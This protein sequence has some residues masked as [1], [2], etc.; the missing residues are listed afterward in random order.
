MGADARTPLQTQM[1][2]TNKI[3]QP[4]PESL[5]QFSHPHPQVTGQT[6]GSSQRCTHVYISNNNTVIS[7]TDN[8]KTL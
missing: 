2:L 7:I 1:H 6:I 5:S 3:I 4:N 8:T